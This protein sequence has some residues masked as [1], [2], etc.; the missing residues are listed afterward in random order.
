MDAEKKARLEAKGWKVGTVTEF[1]GLTPE[2]EAYIESELAVEQ[3]RKRV[4][5]LV[6][7]KRGRILTQAALAKKLK[8]TQPRVARIEAANSS[9][10]LDTLIRAALEAGATVQEISRTLG[11]SE[12]K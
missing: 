5:D 4:A 11:M 9:I 7:A 1:L 2:D 3:M 8:T 10:P 12:S 6:H